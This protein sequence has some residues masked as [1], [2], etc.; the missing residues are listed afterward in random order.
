MSRV[1]PLPLKSLNKT[2]LHGL[3]LLLLGRYKTRYA[4]CWVFE[5]GFEPKYNTILS[6][7]SDYAQLDG[8][9]YFC[10]DISMQMFN[11]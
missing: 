7:N 10:V 1:Y 5:G 9:L 11:D 2:Q 3:T 4:D 8:S 6:L